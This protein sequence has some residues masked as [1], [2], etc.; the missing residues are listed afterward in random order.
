MK[1]FQTFEQAFRNIIQTIHLR[2]D[3]IC[4]ARK[5]QI[6]YESLSMQYRVSNP[7]S[8]KFENER[9]GRITYE[10]AEMFYKWMISGCTPEMTEEFGAKYSNVKEFLAKPVSPDLPSNFNAFYGPRILAQLPKIKKELLNLNSRR[11]VI[12]ILEPGDLELLDKVEDANLEF[13]CCDGVTFNS[14]KGK[15]HAHVHMRS[16]NMGNVAKLDMYLWGRFQCELAADLNLEVGHF[17]SSIVSAHIFES[18]FEY[19]RSLSII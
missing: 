2:P 10:Y 9:I 13:P 8:F 19:F 12:S 15:L 1:T 4:E 17:T 18:D 3:E 14:R 16:N 5:G 11:A 7:A 6:M